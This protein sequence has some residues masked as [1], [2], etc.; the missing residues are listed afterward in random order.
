MC[1]FKFVACFWTSFLLLHCLVQIRHECFCLVLSYFALPCLGV[2][3]WR[4][5]LFWRLNIW[6]DLGKRGGGWARRSTG[7]RTCDQDIFVIWGNNLN[8]YLLN[9]WKEMIKKWPASKY[10]RTKQT[11]WTSDQHINYLILISDCTMART[12]IDNKKSLSIC[13]MRS[14]LISH[15]S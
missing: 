5:A 6:V 13:K 15:P 4:T 14:A 12:I 3:S 10:N 11:V 2:I 7:R 9:K 1:V 8:I